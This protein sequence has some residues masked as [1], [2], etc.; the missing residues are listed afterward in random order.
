MELKS[1]LSWWPIDLSGVLFTMRA[2]SGLA[3]VDTFFETNG[4]S[5]EKVAVDPSPCVA[6][7]GGAVGYPS[8][9]WEVSEE[10]S[11]KSLGPKGTRQVFSQF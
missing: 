8:Y 4:C 6:Y 2:R 1:T 3:A 7:Q 11:P 10:H 5:S 9:Y